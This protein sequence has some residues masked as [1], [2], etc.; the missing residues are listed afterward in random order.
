MNKILRGSTTSIKAFVGL[1][2][3]ERQSDPVL[4]LCLGVFETLVKLMRR[5]EFCPSR[6]V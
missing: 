3:A 5:L 2:V 1:M 4:I 6:R